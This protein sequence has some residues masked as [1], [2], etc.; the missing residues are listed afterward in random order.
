M[1]WLQNRKLTKALTKVISL[2]KATKV[3]GGLGPGASLRL[4][5]EDMENKEPALISTLEPFLL[6]EWQQ[7]QGQAE[8]PLGLSILI[9]PTPI[10]TTASRTDMLQIPLAG[11]VA[12]VSSGA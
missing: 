9:P 8:A 6:Q 4:S 1:Y 3:P 10:P 2:C 7:G 12:L 11:L 5:L